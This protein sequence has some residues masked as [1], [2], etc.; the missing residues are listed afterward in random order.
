VGINVVIFNSSKAAGFL[1]QPALITIL[2]IDEGLGHPPK[3]VTA[4]DLG[5][6]KEVQVCR[7]HITVY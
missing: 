1:A 4:L 6:E 5:T 3:L 7:V 2:G